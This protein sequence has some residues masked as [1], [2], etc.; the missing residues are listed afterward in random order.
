MCIRDR[1][2]KTIARAPG[3]ELGSHTFSHLYLREKGVT[4]TD[5]AADLAATADLYKE[6]Y[7]TIP[8]S[9]VF[10]RNQCAFIDVVRA[11]TIRMWRGN[12][13]PW[14]YDCE[15]SEHYSILPR[16]LRLMDELNPLST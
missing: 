5:V 11:S 16:V 12:Q 8:R 9:L 7:D 6:R 15:D 3:Q 1:L 10:P 4:P 2:L 14:Y 13:G